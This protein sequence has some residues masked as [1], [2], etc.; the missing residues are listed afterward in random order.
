MNIVDYIGREFK[1]I[2]FN[3]WGLVREFYRAELGQDIPAVNVNPENYRAIVHAFADSDIRELFS[4][5]SEPKNYDVVALC[6]HSAFDHIGIFFDGHILHNDNPAG[7][8]LQ[9][10]PDMQRRGWAINGYY[11]LNK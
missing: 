9:S 1:P 7:V 8:L 10:I 11:R 4:R 3:C 6:R 5:V 2:E